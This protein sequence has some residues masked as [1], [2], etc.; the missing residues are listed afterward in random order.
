MSKYLPTF[1]LG[2]IL[3]SP[4][5]AN[6]VQ[7]CPR[8]ADLSRHLQLNASQTEKLEKLMAK[9]R[10]AMDKIHDQYQQTHD[11]ERAEVEKLRSSQ[12]A[13]MATILNDKQM[14]QFDKMLKRRHPPHPPMPDAEMRA[15]TQTH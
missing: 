5:L 14:A 10:A 11:N 7:D 15:P 9:H 4:V 6:S 12:R 13:E 1:M 8:Q 3:S 2:L